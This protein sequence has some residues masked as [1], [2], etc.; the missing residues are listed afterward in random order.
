MRKH[1][2]STVPCSAQQSPTFGPKE[3]PPP[4]RSGV[5]REPIRALPVPFWAY[6]FFP[7][8]RTS[9]LVNVLAV[10]YQQQHRLGVNSRKAMAQLD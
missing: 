5:R 10:P 9:A 6:G 4:G 3:T 1:T 7:P 2:F 8:P